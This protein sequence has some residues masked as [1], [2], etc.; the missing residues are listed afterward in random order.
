MNQVFHQ[1]EG[2]NRSGFSTPQAIPMT[3]SGFS[4]KAPGDQIPG[5]I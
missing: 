3:T 2:L 4:F 5:H 1:V